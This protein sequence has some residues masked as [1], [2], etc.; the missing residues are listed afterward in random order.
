MF[1]EDSRV[2]IPAILHFMRLGYH[3]IPHAQQKREESTNIFKDI[4]LTSI[5]AINP[6][7]SP[8]V[9]ERHFHEIVLKLDYDDLGKDFYKSLV[10][11]SGIKLIDF[12]NFDN[13]T[14][15]VTSELTCKHGEEEFRP[16]ITVL[17][18]GMPLAFVEVKKP[19]NKEGI[20]AERTRINSRFNNKHFRKFAN[21]TQLM[22]FSNNMEY[23]DGVIEPVFGAFYATAA[24]GD[25]KLNY[26]REDLDYPVT[27]K[28]NTLTDEQ[29]SALLKDNNLLVIKHSPEF[30]TNK[31]ENT[32]THRILTSLFTR[33]RLRFILKYAIA[34][35][36]TE[37]GNE[38][39]IMRYPQMFA[40]KAITAK[41]DQGQK[42]GIIWHT[43]G[44]GKTAL[45]Y[46]NVKHLI[47]Y[48]Q[49][50]K[51]IPKFY[52]VVDRIDLMNQA[53]IEFENRDL[54]VN[55]VNSRQEFI[56]DL[57]VVGAI[58]NHSGKPEITVVNIQK[59]SQDSQVHKILEYDVN[60][61]RVYFL[62][63]AH[64][65][66]NPKGNYLANLINSD[67]NAVIIALTGTPL[68][69]E[70]AKEYDSKLLFGNY[71]HKYYY[72]R[73][74]A[75][76]YTLRL[77]RE[78]IESSFKMEMKEVIESIKILKG[79]IKASEIY[80]HKKFATGLLDYITKDLESFRQMENDPT[81]GGMVVCD[82]SQQAKILFELF[83]EKYG[84][85]EIDAAKLDQVAEEPT[86]YGLPKKTKLTAALIL[87]DEND[88]FVRKEL[89]KAYKDAKIDL[90]FVYNMLL[91]GF[92]AKRLK[93]LYLARVIQDHNLLQ[94]LTRVNR[95]YKNYKYGYVVDFADISKAFDRTNQ[96]Y[97]KELQDQLGDEM[98][99][100]S[101]LF[102]SQEEIKKEIEEIK[103][104]LL[105]YDT[106]NK[107]L[108][109]QQI[110]QIKDKK[111]LLKLINALRM[112][113][114]NKNL[115]DLNDYADLK[116]ILDFQV[117]IRLL[118][119]AQN[120]LD[121]MNLVENIG[122]ENTNQNLL[123]VALEDIV[124]QFIKKG[125]IE[126]KLAD[127]Y[128]DQLRKTR[129]ILQQ[130]IDPVD[131]QFIS[132]K[133]ELERIFK[134]KNL[135]ETN[136]EDL[137]EN[138]S[139]LQK[140]YDHAKELNRKNNLLNA[141]Y[142][143]DQKYCRIHKRLI[144]KGTLNTKESQLLQVLSQIRT[145]VETKLEGQENLLANDAVFNRFM[146][147]LV[148]QNFVINEKIP[149]DATTRQS[150]SN[151]IAQEYYKSYNSLY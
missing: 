96:L 33:E 146:L 83:E 99:M 149:L 64:R 52:F 125:E 30:Q 66:Y 100:Y 129:E 67:R 93:K 32:P 60:T 51:T 142:E 5:A 10:A 78:E 104:T 61:Q 115:I 31:D 124:F 70:V 151:L 3:Y 97:F 110:K 46:Y 12:E 116:D 114:E 126:L 43:Q 120:R 29:E 39:H 45:A 143:N 14:F 144:E 105:Y 47:D 28:L 21:S 34:Y 15:H 81:L 44:S 90:L 121:N 147:K 123:N 11:T 41:L 38:K 8:E 2:K 27:Q 128:K 139:L 65:S 127:E 150:I 59:F 85:Q 42:K 80:A 98:E 71:I 40:T 56:N 74:I 112:A 68:L 136:Q 141:K 19:H 131:P 94:T 1:N 16:D 6:D 23:E 75:D 35:V 133:E 89:V 62:D 106:N 111:E 84:I 18:N 138:M 132:L 135:Y 137:V 24:Y 72:N 130:N 4:F 7:F 140:I 58:H 9:I 109:S 22:V 25:V 79:E 92:D 101:H 95:P 20:I 148:T 73:S 54:K 103:E 17:I 36:K 55:K 48:Y 26:F 108:F 37:K 63:E 77:I 117:Y 57:Q 76:G 113:K 50:S 118:T 119:E 91:T 145:E 87:H 134:K 53:V 107:E 122:H 82:S 102:K 88:K 49:Q 86:S 13:N 69:R